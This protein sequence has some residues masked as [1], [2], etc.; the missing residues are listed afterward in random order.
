[1]SKHRSWIGIVFVLLAGVASWKIYY[2]L[3]S[4]FVGL[5]ESVGIANGYLQGIIFIT[6]VF[7]ILYFIG[8][9]TLI[10]EALK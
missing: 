6:I 5:F 10:L 1:M 4:L 3:D 7:A 9:K 2:L 8:R